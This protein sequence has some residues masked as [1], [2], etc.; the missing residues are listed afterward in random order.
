MENFDQVFILLA[1]KE[2][3]HLNSDILDTGLF[4]VIV[5]VAV[6]VYLIKKE[7]LPL[8]EERHK[9]ISKAV[10]DAEEKVLEANRRLI[11]AQQQLT[12]AKVIISEIHN[13]TLKTKQTL[14]ESDYKQAN[15][16][17]TIRFSRALATLSFREQQIF[18]EVKQEIISLTLKNVLR[19]VQQKLNAS[20]QSIVINNSI[21]KLGGK[22]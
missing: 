21:A 18:T 16:D 17:L 3:I 13:E 12:Q 2:G 20:K 7:I 6:L 15:D 19:Q 9:E 5:L 22:L 8:L 4:N 10:F 14:L 1:E 11:N